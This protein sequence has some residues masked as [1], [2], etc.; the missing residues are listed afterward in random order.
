MGVYVSYICGTKIKYMINSIQSIDY[1]SMKE[2][3]MLVS[4]KKT[5]NLKYKTKVRMNKKGNPYH[6][7]IIKVVETNINIGLSYEDMV[8]IYELRE[9]IEREEEFK[10]EKPK[11]VHHISLCVLENDNDSNVHYLSYFPYRQSGGNL[12]TPRVKYFLEGVEVER[13]LF[14]EWEI[15]SSGLTNTQTTTKRVFNQRVDLKNI[16]EYTFDSVR[17]VREEV[18]VLV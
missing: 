1:V 17:Y 8:E 12:W 18:E 10:S 9:G 15:K 2:M 11:G 6:D 5:I 14:E 7:R 4:G 13:S 16:L 3:F